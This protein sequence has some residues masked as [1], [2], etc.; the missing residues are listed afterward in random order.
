MRLKH[1]FTDYNGNDGNSERSMATKV[2]QEYRGRKKVMMNTTIVVLVAAV[3]VEVEAKKH[4]RTA[5]FHDHRS[6]EGFSVHVTS[7]SPPLV[8]QTTASKQT[9]INNT[10]EKVQIEFQ[11]SE[12]AKCE[13][14]L[15]S[16]AVY[17]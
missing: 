7:P 1:I 17:S 3:M 13:G 11:Q 12:A 10:F 8:S 16:P 4:V 15:V 6:S 2:V 9:R 14:S 5:L